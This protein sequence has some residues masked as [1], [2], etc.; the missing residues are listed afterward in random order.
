MFVRKVS[1][2]LKPESLDSFITLM[3]N[4]IL[5]WLRKQPGFLDWLILA[6]PHDSEVATVSFWDHEDNAQAYNTHGYPEALKR[7]EDLLDSHP[8]VKTFN[9]LSSTLGKN[10]AK[11]N[12]GTAK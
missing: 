8:Y 4:E 9:V 7:L 2:R 3:E 6:A 1:A 10:S 12:A 11:A 5:P